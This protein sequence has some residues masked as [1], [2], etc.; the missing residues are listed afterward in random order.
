VATVAEKNYTLEVW[1]DQQ[2]INFMLLDKIR[3]FMTAVC[4][5]AGHYIFV[6]WFLFFLLSFFLA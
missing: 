2:K 1:A 3:I 4:N 5:R 6:L